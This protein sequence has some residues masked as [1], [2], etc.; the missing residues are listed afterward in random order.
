MKKGKLVKSI[1][2]RMKIKGNGVVN[3]DGNDQKWMY[4]DSEKFRHL[5]DINSNVKYAK[6]HFFRNSDGKLEDYKIVISS[7]CLRNAIFKNEMIAQT[8]NIISVPNLLYS[9]IGSPVGVVRGYLFAEKSLTLKRASAFNILDAVDT[10]KSMS[11]LPVNTRSGQKNTDK[12]IKD[13]SLFSVENVGDTIYTTRGRIDLEQ[14]QFISNDLVFDRLAFD[15][16]RF[17]LFAN[18]IKNY[19][20]EFKNKLGYY[21]KKGDINN[22]PEFGLLFNDAQV[23]YFVKYLLER[24]MSLDI[25]RKNA[26]A[27]VEE[28]EIKFITDPIND[29]FNNS[30][31]GWI[32]LAS[33]EDIDK[34]N[35]EVETYY[36]EVKEK[37]AIAIRSNITESVQKSNDVKKADKVAKAEAKKTK[38]ATA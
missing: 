30:E 15:S 24:L 23:K 14:L 35:F 20:G 29:K 16:D 38:K 37:E 4:K 25:T 11:S 22:I 19:L 28:L 7:D 27:H 18:S 12:D 1:E 2:F 9:F 26:Y 3:F 33:R 17:D 6:K 13:T 21:L 10:G 31:D 8:P 34:L 5:Y 36:T 32:K